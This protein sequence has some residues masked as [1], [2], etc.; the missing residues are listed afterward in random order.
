MTVATTSAM[1]GWVAP[2]EMDRS[3]D[4]LGL[5]A[6]ADAYAERLLPGVTV[7]TNRARYLTFLCWAGD[8]KWTADQTDR[9]EVALALGEH[10]RHAGEN[11]STCSFLGKNRAKSLALGDHERLPRR[12]HQQTAR[13]LYSGL[14]ETTS[15]VDSNGTLTLVG[16]RLAGWFRPGRRAIPTRVRDCASLPCLG[17]AGVHERRQLATALLDGTDEA[18]TRESTYRTVPSRIW[19]SRDVT[20]DLLRHYL[21]PA[22]ARAGGVSALLHE[23]AGFELAAYALKRFFLH[24]YGKGRGPNGRLPASTRLAATLAFFIDSSS[25]LRD[26]AA[27]LRKADALGGT[28]FLTRY[29]YTRAPSSA[30]K[31]GDVVVE[32]HLAAKPEAP[33]V[34][35]RWRVVRQGLAPANGDGLHPYRLPSFANLLRDLG[36][37]GNARVE[38]GRAA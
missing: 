21:E 13:I 7:A 5:Q 18:A 9:W 25:L 23:V 11:A 38:R 8:K 1:P 27:H 30:S 15:A 31:L 36:H 3:L 19:A 10:R 26:V 35:E 32:L 2:A 4:P 20:A 16:E 12:L 6:I 28:E 33:W 29:G 34:D 14:L 37:L 22:R 17:W 24:F